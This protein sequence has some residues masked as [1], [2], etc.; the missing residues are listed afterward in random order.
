[1]TGPGLEG[2]L[3]LIRSRL[4]GADVPV[5]VGIE[6]AGHYHQPLL[7]SSVW[8]AGRQVLELNPAHVA[9]QRRV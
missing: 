7:G 4:T 6:A 8:P 2:V 5:K 1:M 3:P 9:E